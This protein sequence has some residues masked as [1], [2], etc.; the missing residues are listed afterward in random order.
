MPSRKQQ[1]AINPDHLNPQQRKIEEQIAE[2]KKRWNWFNKLCI[3]SHYLDKAK[4]E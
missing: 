3:N 4:I 2:E 1:I